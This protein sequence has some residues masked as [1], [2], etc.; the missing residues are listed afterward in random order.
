MFNVSIKNLD[1]GIDSMLIKFTDGTKL[2]GTVNILDNRMRIQMSSTN[3]RNGLGGGRGIKLETSARHK[4]WAGI[5]N[6]QRMRKGQWF[7][8][9]GTDEQRKVK[10]G[11]EVQ[12]V[13]VSSWWE[14]KANIGRTSSNRLLL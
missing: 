10:T 11:P 2:G 4:T 9:K 3:S 8:R 13:S 7:C 1:D 5:I 14:K 12:Q 6:A